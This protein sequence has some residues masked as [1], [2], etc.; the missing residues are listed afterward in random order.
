MAA[1]NP[2]ANFYAAEP[3]VA[4][5]LDPAKGIYHGYP[6][7]PLKKYLASWGL[8]TPSAALLGQF[9]MLDYVAY[10]PFVDMDSTDEQVLVNDAL[11]GG[12]VSRYLTNGGCNV[13]MVTAAPTIG[14]GQFTF[15]YTNQDGVLKT[16]PNQ[17]CGTAVSN[18]SN[19]KDQPATVG[20]VGPFLPL[21]QGDTG[22]RALQ[23]V[24]FSVP[25]GGLCALV[26]VRPLSSMALLEINAPNEKQFVKEGPN[27]P[28]IYD[29]AYLGLIHNCAASVAA[30]QLMGYATFVW[31]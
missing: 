18:I 7:S 15:T 21:A 27:T 29:D 19:L 8:C 16:S 28:Q 10:Y 1:G 26:L 31:K 20:G 9:M 6:V 24:T 23:S 4:D 5:V 13:M 2:P 30:A 11:A 17:F 25:N 3:L 14:G 12:V 22:V